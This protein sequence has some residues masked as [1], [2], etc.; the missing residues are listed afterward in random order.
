MAKNCVRRAVVLVLVQAAGAWVGTTV[1]TGIGTPTRRHALLLAAAPPPPPPP[2]AAQRFGGSS[3][4]DDGGSESTNRLLAFLMRLAARPADAIRLL[5]LLPLALFALVRPFRRAVRTQKN[6]L[7]IIVRLKLFERQSFESEAARLAARDALDEELAADFATFIGNMRGAFVKAAQVLGSLEPA[8]VRPAYVRRLEPMT[9]AAPGGRAWWRVKRQLTRELRRAGYSSIDDV[10]SSFDPTPVGVASVGQVHRAV[11]RANG[12][13]VAVKLQ[14]P[15]AQ[16]LILSDLGNIHNVLRSLGKEAEAGVVREYRSRMSLEFDYLAEGSTMNRVAE[17]FGSGPR[18][19]EYFGGG[20]LDANGAGRLAEIASTHVSERVSVPRAYPELTTRRLLVM[21][22]LHG[23]S[24]R[25]AL[26]GKVASY[27][28][29]PLPLR[30][31]LLLGLRRKTTRQLHTLLD[32]QAQQIFR[33]GTFNADPHPG[34]VFLLSGGRQ[35]G[36]LDFGCAKTLRP[37]QRV[38]LARLYVALHDGDEDGVVAAAVAMGTRTKNMNRDVLL[39]FATHFFDRDIADPPMSPPAFLL[40]LRA[41]D[42]ITSLPREYMLVA[43]SSL[44][45]RGLSAKLR[46]PQKISDVW[47]AEARRYLDAYEQGLERAAAGPGGA[48]WRGGDC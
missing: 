46:A 44:L 31:P 24:M 13:E 30:L 25:D 21:D 3:G 48:T 32:A 7:P 26:R 28:S 6:V 8:P 42:P 11:L 41:I 17:F 40:S 43:R 14:Y 35:L 1:R 9:D 12:R 34:N 5:P 2:P 20:Q 47:A 4:D 33:L 18:D 16:R 39:R 23:E 27:Q 36:L 29:Y 22:Y 15:D 19:D 45:L 38:H 37:E 10:F